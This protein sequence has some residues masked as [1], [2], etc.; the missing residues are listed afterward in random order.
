[1]TLHIKIEAY[2]CAPLHVILFKAC[3][4]Q[5]RMGGTEE[6][7][8]WGGKLLNNHIKQQRA[9][10]MWTIHFYCL[11]CLPPGAQT[12]NLHNN[13]DN[14]L[15]TGKSAHVHPHALWITL[16][17]PVNL[18]LWPFFFGA[19]VSRPPLPVTCVIMAFI[20]LQERKGR[21][22]M[23]RLNLPCVRGEEKTALRCLGRAGE[24]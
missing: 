22:E 23:A 7:F 1:M 3:L 24:K 2:A 12:I 9:S 15:H 10:P 6:R 19:E 14:V 17:S 16:Q 5:K 18:L 20:G 13:K 4:L 8:R 11:R 21:Q